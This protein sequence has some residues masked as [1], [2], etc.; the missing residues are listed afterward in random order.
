MERGEAGRDTGIHVYLSPYIHMPILR[1][2][3][4]VRT[5]NSLMKVSMPAPNSAMLPSNLPPVKVALDSSMCTAPP[6]S[7]ALFLMKFESVTVTF[8]AFLATQQQER[9][10][11]VLE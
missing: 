1:I 10:Q 3:R 9:R 6:K 4:V 7:V 5:W 11:K 2:S 8:S